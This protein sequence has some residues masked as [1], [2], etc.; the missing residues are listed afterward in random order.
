MS[1]TTNCWN[2][3]SKRWSSNALSRPSE[4]HRIFVST[5]AT[6]S[7]SVTKLSK[8]VGTKV[9][10]AESAKR[11]L[12]GRQ[13][14]HPARRYVVERTLVWLSKCRGLLMLREEE[15]K[16][17]R[18]TSVRLHPALVSPLGRSGCRFPVTTR[19]CYYFSF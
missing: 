4:T 9:T 13:K 1:T 14:K 6:T 12:T 8:I 19:C 15:R 3:Q 11:N 2:R 16:L 7:G 10:S 18:P 17:S 5:K